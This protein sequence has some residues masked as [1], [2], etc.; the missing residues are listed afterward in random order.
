MK[1][2]WSV[3]K[4]MS[5]VTALIG[6]L[7]LSWVAVYLV[8]EAICARFSRQLPGLVQ[9]IIISISGLFLYGVST[10]L[11]GL[12]S[13]LVIASRE[14]WEH[15]FWQDM[16]NAIDRIAKGDFRVD[17]DRWTKLNHP[18]T[19]LVDRI[20]S[21]AASLS[22]MEEM[23]Q[24][25]ISN[26]AHE[27]GSPL[28]S[29]RG[30]ARAL[31][32]ENLS[33]EQRIHYLDVIEDECIRL[34]KLSENL[35]RLAMLNSEHY[36]FHPT[37]YRLD[38]QL[39]SLIL[40]CEPQW[41]GKE[42]NMCVMLEEVVITADH[43]LMSQVWLNLIDNAIKFTPKGGTITMRLQQHG[44]QAI[45][46]ISDT[47]P[48]IA[49][50]DLPRIFERFYKVDKSRNRAAG[51]SGL[52]LSIVKKIV[53]MHRGNISVRSRLGEG[54]EFIVQLPLRLQDCMFQRLSVTG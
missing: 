23:R 42:L 48:G 22:A 2:I 44:E 46:T 45:V 9:Q 13:R 40:E 1:R 28:T 36:P 5:A 32:N 24:E 10:R 14:G 53:D 8:T 38:K 3:V 19:E 29:I 7:C 20:N 31:K 50:H 6:L 41:A 54:T 21:M 27:I 47:G 49:E 17:L 35:L 30:F 33:R 12:L 25:F 52:G 16:V 4:R 51:G 39:K 43:D 26:V 18:F 15:P 37:S 11:T 34:S